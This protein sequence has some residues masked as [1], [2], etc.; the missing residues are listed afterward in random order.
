MMDIL[1]RIEKQHLRDEAKKKD[2][3]EKKKQKSPAK[4]KDPSP[5][6]VA[7]ESQPPT[8]STY[9]ATMEDPTIISEVVTNQPPPE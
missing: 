2:S 5:D 3:K 7:I 4:Q 8:S 1:K 6:P 9:E